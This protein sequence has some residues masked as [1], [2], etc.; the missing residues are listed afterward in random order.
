MT[1]DAVKT[2]ER[3]VEGL[4][5]YAVMAG[6]FLL[7]AI[8]GFGPN[9][10]DILNGTK[11]N[12]PLL[13]HIHAASMTAWLLLLLAQAGFVSAGR[14]T[15]HQALGKLVLIVAPVVLVL[16][17]M[18][19]LKD[20][21]DD[22]LPL[23]AALIQGKRIIVFSLGVGL[24]VLW[25]RKYPEAHKRLMFLATFAVLD[26]AFFRMGW[27]LPG[28][29]FEHPFAIGHAWQLVLLVPFLVYDL[30]TRGRIH[31][32]FLIGVPVIIAVQTTAALIY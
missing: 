17:V 4:R 11:T 20:Y 16:M 12:P 1:D 6:V 19:V 8:I 28:F 29:G 23:Y 15:L 30:S 26:A 32:V 10:I 25:R 27:F 3:I 14:Q 13:I 2:G 5:F 9:S 18:I 24:A 31:P 7:V 21:Q 22:A